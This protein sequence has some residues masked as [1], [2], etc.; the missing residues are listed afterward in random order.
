MPVTFY[1]IAFEQ[2]PADP[3]WYDI[4]R[5]YCFDWDLFSGKDWELLLE[6]YAS[7]PDWRF[8]ERQQCPRWFSDFDDSQNGYLTASVEPPG[9]QV[10]GTLLHAEWAAW[11]DQFLK[12]TEVLPSRTL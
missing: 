5:I 1:D 12:L 6:A 4:E 11:N 10:F 8:L 9:L 3:D 2:D 7:L